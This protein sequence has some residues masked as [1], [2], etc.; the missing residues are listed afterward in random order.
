MSMGQVAFKQKG[1]DE[2][3][4]PDEMEYPRKVAELMGVN[5]DEVMFAQ[6]SWPIDHH[7]AQATGYAELTVIDEELQEATSNNSYL[8]TFY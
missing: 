3:A 5:V 6:I 2:Q 1:R 4:E 8:M 7:L